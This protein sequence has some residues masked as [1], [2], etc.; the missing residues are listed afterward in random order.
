MMSKKSIDKNINIANN[1]VSKTITNKI[2]SWCKLNT[3]I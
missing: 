3:T 1:P 2:G